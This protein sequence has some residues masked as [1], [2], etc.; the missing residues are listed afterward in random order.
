MGKISKPLDSATLYDILIELNIPMNF[1][2]DLPYHELWNLIS[3]RSNRL[4]TDNKKEAS[5]RRA[6]QSDI[7][8]FLS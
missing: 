4:E 6:S 7:D 3:V 2:D 8:S 1:I 5:Q